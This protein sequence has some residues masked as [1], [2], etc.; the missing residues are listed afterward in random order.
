MSLS[1][2]GIEV[3]SYRIIFRLARD[4]LTK[5]DKRTCYMLIR[6]IHATGDLTICKDVAFSE[7]FIE[8][9]IRALQDKCSVVADVNMV[10]AGIAHRASLIGLHV[11]TVSSYARPESTDK[12]RLSGALRRLLSHVPETACSVYVI[13]CSPLVLRELL[14]LVSTGKIMPRIVIGCPP[15]F[16]NA[17]EAKR[18]LE[19]AG[20]PY[21][22]V[23]GT[24]GGSA[25][26]VSVFN[27]LVD[28]LTGRA[29]II[30][31]AIESRL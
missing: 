10:T 24:R 27:S 9:G 5:L 11:Y 1:I 15:G 3:E 21:F 16:V 18:A 6:V 2:S 13:G 31:S 26:A 20:V 28:I 4:Y 8:S 17:P 19:S 12:P 14:E 23:R 22:T 29:D 25:I 30:M 7:D